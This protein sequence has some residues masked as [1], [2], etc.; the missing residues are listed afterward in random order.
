MRA[1]LASL[2]A[3][4]GRRG[5]QGIARPIIPHFPPSVFPC[6]PLW[7]LLFAGLFSAA[8]GTAEFKT[9]QARWSDTELVLGNAH[10]ERHWRIENGL[11]T[12]TSFR[13]RDTGTEWIRQPAKTPA[14]IPAGLRAEPRS[15]TV[16]S[17]SGQLGVTEEE[18]LEVRLEARGTRN[19]NYSFRI[20]PGATGVEI[21]F[22]G[23]A[24]VPVAPVAAA[25]GTPVTG[26]ETFT[27]KADAAAGDALENLML[28]P[29]HLRLTQ[30]TLADQTDGHNELVQ[31]NEWM[32]LN[33]SNLTLAGNLFAVENALT[34]EGL[35]F[36]K[37]APLP[38]ARSIQS[39]GD[40]TVSA[41]AR[42]VRFIGQSY[43]FVLLT[44]SGGKTGRTTVLHQFQR[45][46][47]RYQPD[48]DG[49]FL[50]NTW[51][52][53][54]RDAR[55]NEAFLLQ[56]IAAGS[57]LGAE[58]QQIDDGWQ[59]GLSGNSAFATN[60]AWGSFWNA[61]SN[62]WQPNPKRFPHGL[63]PVVAAAREHGMQLGLWFGPDSAGGGT[64]WNRDTER[65]LQLY[66][67]DGIRYF[68]LD[69]V[70]FSQATAAGHFQRLTGELLNQSQGEIAIDLDVTAGLRPGY[71]GA[72]TVGPIFV[73]NRYT[74][75]ASYWP[76]L[77][78]RNL[79]KLSQYV[80]P[81]RLRM[82]FLNNTRNLE[83]YGDDPLAPARYTPDALFATVMFANPLGWFETSHLPTNYFNAVAPLVAVWKRERPALFGGTILPVGTAPDGVAWTGFVSLARDGGAKSVLLFRELNACPEWSLDLGGFPGENRRLTVLAGQGEAA[84]SGQ[85]LNVKIP[86]TLQYLWVRIEGAN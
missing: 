65:L 39:V 49:L 48:R 74:D 41:R 3:W 71:F 7:L 60:G 56:E 53:R 5:G 43:P 59:S 79:W 55:I 19:L 30:V 78:L 37:R 45:Q 24:P 18:S 28:T 34:G 81:V 51:G 68:K 4:V 9:C 14:P 25:G 84:L 8:A 36:L 80:D 21:L 54:S 61:N 2:E 46:L 31:E 22:D 83:K 82:E 50:C 17:R 15:V 86:G 52:D 73:E 32:L 70:N 72:M 57:R 20:F 1:V 64:N 35:V 10:F 75:A 26:L 13:N 85:Q 47:R 66:R 58:V 29:S 38:T 16:T 27:A 12:A 77:T 11:L 76:H 44:Y 33:E 23:D 6:V 63:K 62:F 69:A 42:Q 67:E 40:C